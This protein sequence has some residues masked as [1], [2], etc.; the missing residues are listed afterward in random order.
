MKLVIAFL[1]A[2]DLIRAGL[3][4]DVDERRPTEGRTVVALDDGVTF[5]RATAAEARLIARS[6]DALA[7]EIEDVERRRRARAADEVVTRAF[8]PDPKPGPEVVR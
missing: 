4:E 2:P 1:D 8:G 6:F 3:P 5:L 7:F